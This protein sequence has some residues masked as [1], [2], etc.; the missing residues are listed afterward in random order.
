MTSSSGRSRAWAEEIA[1]EFGRLEADSTPF[2]KSGFHSGVL[3]IVSTF[4]RAVSLENQLRVFSLRGTR[5][6]R[7]NGV[8]SGRDYT[9]STVYSSLCNSAV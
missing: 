8:M 2:E 5:H 6:E 1:S 4:L 3:S 7:G 9:I